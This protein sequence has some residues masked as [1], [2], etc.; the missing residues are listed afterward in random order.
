MD[1]NYEEA[2]RLM[3]SDDRI[4]RYL[5]LF[6]RDTNFHVMCNAVNNNDFKTAF[7]AAHTL[8]GVALNLSLTALAD[9]IKELT[10]LLRGEIPVRGISTLLRKTTDTYVSVLECI[11]TLVNEQP[12]G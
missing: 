10:E 11:N 3:G 5:K 7:N 4:M 9:Q 6:Q 2:V 12:K 8:K 1:G